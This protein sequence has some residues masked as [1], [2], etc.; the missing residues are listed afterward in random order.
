[1]EL[2][3]IVQELLQRLAC[4]LGAFVEKCAEVTNPRDDVLGRWRV[5]R[6]EPAASFTNSGAPK[7]GDL[8]PVLA[9]ASVCIKM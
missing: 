7:K 4:V 8:W 9:K 1:M 6:F 3:A 5:E 2:Y